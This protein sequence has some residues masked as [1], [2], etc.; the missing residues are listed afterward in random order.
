MGV[1]SNS[2]NERGLR[3]KLSLPEK[4]PFWTKKS[5]NSTKMPKM[6]SVVLGNRADFRLIYNLGH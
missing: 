6:D 1:S 3:F 4:P 2:P 5:Q